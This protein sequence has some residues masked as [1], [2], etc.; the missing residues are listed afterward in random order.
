MKEKKLKIT[1]S[2]LTNTGKSTMMRFIY[3]QLLKNGFNVEMNINEDF[4]NEDQ[5]HLTIGHNFN[6]RLEAIKSKTEIRLNEVQ[7]NSEAIE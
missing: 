2:G 3:L 5:F 6:K 7:A 1:V 4:K